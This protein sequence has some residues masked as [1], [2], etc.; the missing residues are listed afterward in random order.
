MAR[1]RTVW[2]V[3]FMGRCYLAYKVV[4]DGVHTETHVR[5]TQPRGVVK[6]SGVLRVI[7]DVAYITKA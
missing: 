6:G 7:E 2:S 5:K 4:C 3:H 1:G